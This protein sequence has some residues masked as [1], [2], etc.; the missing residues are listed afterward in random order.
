MLTLIG[1]R[2]QDP[3]NLLHLMGKNKLAKRQ[4]RDLMLLSLSS[5]GEKEHL[6]LTFFRGHAPALS[7]P[8][9]QHTSYQ[10]DQVEK[11]KH[12]ILHQ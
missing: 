11:L 9:L 7:G 4:S 1:Y 8:F 12:L 5:L 3:F 10:R 2:F 6:L